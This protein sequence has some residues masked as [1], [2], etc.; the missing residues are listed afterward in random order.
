VTARRAEERAEDQRRR[1]IR[2]GRAL[3]I[4]GATV[5]VQSLWLL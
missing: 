5:F 2:Y 1:L 3:M 4:V